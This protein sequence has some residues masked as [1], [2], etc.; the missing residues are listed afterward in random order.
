M[1]K[2]V[3][4]ER[5]EASKILA[6]IGVKVPTKAEVERETPVWERLLPSGAKIKISMGKSVGKH[7]P[8][9][10]W[11]VGYAADGRDVTPYIS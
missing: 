4:L 10:Y 9:V 11:L 3:K 7:K 8:M 5:N 2:S 1:S 6:I